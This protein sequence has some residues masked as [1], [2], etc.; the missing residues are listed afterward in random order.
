MDLVKLKPVLSMKP[1]SVKRSKRIT[2]LRRLT[3]L[4]FLVFI[5]IASLRHN[6]LPETAGTASLDA[7]CPFGG[8]ETFWRY[9]TQGAY[10]PKTH[11]SN[12][13]L[14]LG[15]FLGTLIAGAAFCGWICPFGS[16]QDGLTWL[17]THLKLPEIHVPDRLDAILRYGRYLLLALI[18]FKTISTV[19]LWFGD[20]DPYRTVFSLGW[21]F[22]FNLAEQWP[23]YVVALVVLLASFFIPRA[24]C[25]YACPLGGALSLLNR[26]SLLSIR[27]S[28]PACKNCRLCEAPCPVGIQ[29]A[30]ARPNVSP[31]CIGCLECVETCPRAGALQ[32]ML[33]PVWVERLAKLVRRMRHPAPVSGD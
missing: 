31:D 7:L 8:L 32:V 22:E 27:R 1:K 4:A 2:I 16:L 5:L 24:W 6:L 17:R 30:K 9:L 28:T 11:L 26:F 19:K 18:L 20:Y 33:F 23:A 12:L 25:K 29:V 14:G 21:W 15:L 13:V 10:I 3:Q